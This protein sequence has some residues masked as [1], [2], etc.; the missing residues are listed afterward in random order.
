MLRSGPNL[1]ASDAVHWLRPFIVQ[2]CVVENINCPSLEMLYF[3]NMKI[4]LYL[5]I[6]KK[7]FF[8]FGDGCHELFTKF[9]AA[10]TTAVVISTLVYLLGTHFLSQKNVV[11]FL[12]FFLNLKIFYPKI[13]SAKDLR[14]KNV[15]LWGFASLSYHCSPP[16][17]MRIKNFY[18][19]TCY[20][21]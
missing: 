5:E 12:I 7:V 16:P 19:R 10:V 15:M 6:M 13:F 21:A 2:T 9:I 1:M 3:R 8:D 17:Q 20:I 14:S 4:V 11:F 18:I